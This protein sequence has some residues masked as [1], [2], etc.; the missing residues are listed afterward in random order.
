M[1]RYLTPFF[2]KKLAASG[3]ML[4][5]TGLPILASHLYEDVVPSKAAEA[6]SVSEPVSDAIASHQTETPSNVSPQE[7]VYQPTPGELNLAY[8]FPDGADTSKASESYAGKAF[9]ELMALDESWMSGIYDLADA[10]PLKMAQALGLPESRVMGAY[11]HRD[12]SHDASNPDT[13]TINTFKRVQISFT[14]GDGAPIEARSNVTD[15]MSMASLYTYFEGVTDYELFLSYARQLWELS[16]SYTVSISPIYH[17][18]GCLDAQAEER[19][20][21][22]LEEEAIAEEQ[23]A[24]ASEVSGTAAVID[25]TGAAGSAADG[26]AAPSTGSAADGAA[27]PAALSDSAS[28]SAEADFA[29]PAQASRVLVAGLSHQDETTAAEETTADAPQAPASTVVTAGQSSQTGLQSTE[30]NTEQDARQHTELDAEQ[31]TASHDSSESSAVPPEATPADAESTQPAAVSPETTTHCPGHVD[32]IVQAKILGL[33]EENGLFACDP[34]GISEN[35]VSDNSWPGWNRYTRASARQLSQQDWFERYGLSISLIS[36]EHALTADEIDAYMNQLPNDLSETRKE[37]IH[38]ALSSVGRVPYY[39]GG[40][41]YA[42]GYSGNSFGAVISPD[43]MGRVLRGLDCSG[44]I[45]WVY[46]SVTGQRLPYESTSG[47][48]ISGTRIN[49]SELKPGDVIVRTGDDAHA[50]MFLGWTADGKIRCIHESSTAV[51]NVTI[52]IRDANWPH[53]RKLID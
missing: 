52:S 28:P 21:Q 45:S 49:R 4:L 24:K 32:L 20:R 25:N 5:L 46:W 41:P 36:P 10:T 38:F 22:Q 19:E 50:V 13:W 26:A 1:N 2:Q 31:N 48:A 23:A 40:K 6:P 8:Y 29:E 11:N 42:A 18:D 44:W 34:H 7:R 15:L 3:L 17:C 16:H 43:H 51:N 53:Y 27:A 14:D 35:P 47:L 30:Q 9:Q 37:L 33:T 39:W 12:E